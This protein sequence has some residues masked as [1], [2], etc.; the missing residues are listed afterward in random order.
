[1]FVLKAESDLNWWLRRF[2][3]RVRLRLTRD[4]IEATFAKATVRHRPILLLKREDNTARIVGIGD[5]QPSDAFSHRIDVL[6]AAGSL[7]RPVDA[8]E[9]FLMTLFRRLPLHYL[10]IRPV[11]VVEGLPSLERALEAPYRDVMVQALRNM[12]ASAVIFPTDS[13]H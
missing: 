10:F 7:L 1:M 12:R 6:R 5:E 2:A 8:A 9:G 4:Y 13:H 11:V 3:P